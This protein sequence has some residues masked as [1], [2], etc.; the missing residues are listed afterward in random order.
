MGKVDI[1]RLLLLVL[2]LRSESSMLAVEI[3][4][5]AMWYKK[6]EYC[7]TG[8]FMNKTVWSKIAGLLNTFI[9]PPWFPFLFIIGLGVCCSLAGTGGG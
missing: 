8:E 4:T 9:D 7:A 5:P 3:T 2:E 1:D 6:G